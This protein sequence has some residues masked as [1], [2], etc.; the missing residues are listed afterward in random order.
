MTLR[1]K[2]IIF[3]NTINVQILFSL[4]SLIKQCHRVKHPKKFT[5]YRFGENFFEPS[6][7]QNKKKKKCFKKRTQ[8]L[9][10]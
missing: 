6:K 2:K 3:S 9:C 7:K 5:T 8:V 1:S 4:T 10:A